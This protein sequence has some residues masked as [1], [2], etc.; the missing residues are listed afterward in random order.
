MSRRT[1]ITCDRCGEEIA[2]NNL[3][4]ESAQIHLNPPREYKGYGGQRIDLCLLCY[5]RFVDFLESGAKM[6][7]ENR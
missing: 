1:T 6:E 5:E 7:G 4:D 3:K 2:V